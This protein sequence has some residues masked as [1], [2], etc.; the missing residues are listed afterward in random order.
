MPDHRRGFNAGAFLPAFDRDFTATRVNGECK[1][2]G[3]QIQR[4]VPC[5]LVS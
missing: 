3:A 5:E 4:I 1:L 2:L